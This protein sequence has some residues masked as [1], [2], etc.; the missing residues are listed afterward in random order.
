MIIAAGLT[1]AWQQIMRFERLATGQVN[2]AREVAW[3]A[4]GKVLNVGLA[5]ARFE[6]P[7]AYD[8]IWSRIEAATPRAMSVSTMPGCTEFTRML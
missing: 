4:S 6:T 7:E 3:C 2:R 8:A 5:L 1:P